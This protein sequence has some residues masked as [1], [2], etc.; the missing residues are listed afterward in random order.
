MASPYNSRRKC[1]GDYANGN[2]WEYPWTPNDSSPVFSNTGQS[3]SP[4]LRK[5]MPA[6]VPSTPLRSDSSILYSP[7]YG[8]IPTPWSVDTIPLACPDPQIS[9]PNVAWADWSH[10]AQGNPPSRT[11]LQPP[12]S[13]SPVATQS[14]AGI[15]TPTP[16]NG[17]DGHTCGHSS[18]AE[19]GYVNQTLD[20]SRSD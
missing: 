18:N 17:E 4:S 13:F 8:T 19:Y 11:V 6:Q 5:A 10:S 1:Q 20:P 14:K 15:E 7:A 3:V 2:G 9:P 16:V 12:I